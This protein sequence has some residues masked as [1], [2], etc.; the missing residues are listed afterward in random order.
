M[1]GGKPV[2]HLQAW[3]RLWKP[4]PPDCESD[5]LRIIKY[6]IYG[7]PVSSSKSKKKKIKKTMPLLILPY[8]LVAS[9]I[10]NRSSYQQN[11]VQR[12]ALMKKRDVYWKGAAKSNHY[13][14]PACSCTYRISCHTLKR[15]LQNRTIHLC[16]SRDKVKTMPNLYL[17]L[18][19]TI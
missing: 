12:R 11:H 4:G 10:W 7:L 1:G 17:I 18:K 8:S 14:P 9:E 19:C 15:S 6:T 2:V 16:V 3:P 5:A 13:G